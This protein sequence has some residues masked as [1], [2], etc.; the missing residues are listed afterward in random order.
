MEDLS[1]KWRGPGEHFAHLAHMLCRLEGLKKLRLEFDDCGGE[2]FPCPVFTEDRLAK[3]GLEALIDADITPLQHI[4]HLE[5]NYVEAPEHAEL[6]TGLALVS[7]GAPLRLV[8][9]D[10]PVPSGLFRFFS[11]GARLPA[12]PDVVLRG[13]EPHTV[14]E[15][16]YVLPQLG[17]RSIANLLIEAD[18]GPYFAYPDLGYDPML[19]KM[20]SFSAF[21]AAIPPSVQQVH[22]DGEAFQ[23][24]NTYNRLARHSLPFAVSDRDRIT[25]EVTSK[26]TC[27][28]VT[29]RGSGY[30]VERT[31][32]RGAVRTDDGLDSTRNGAWQVYARFGDPTRYDE[33]LSDWY[34]FDKVEEPYR[35]PSLPY[36][37]QAV[38][39]HDHHGEGGRQYTS[40]TDSD[41]ETDEDG[42]ERDPWQ[43]GGTVVHIDPFGF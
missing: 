15:L 18:A 27:T 23:V 32:E 16:L 8:E 17:T 10:G 26:P 42:Y 34:R 1:I 24:D 5:L 33:R 28:V 36:P 31:L 30:H 39:A 43:I 22:Y 29:Y 21:L 4:E 6:S 14:K 11:L 25:E 19:P 2:T 7:T 20:P 9:V 13:L 35:D 40:Y 12:I 41:A 38:A 3:F 37:P